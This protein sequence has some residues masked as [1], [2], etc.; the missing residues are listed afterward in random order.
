MFVS[1]P[2]SLSS[3]RHRGPSSVSRS[4]RTIMISIIIVVIISSSGP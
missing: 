4:A 2:G 1:G 3:G